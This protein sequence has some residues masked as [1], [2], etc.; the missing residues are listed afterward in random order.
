MEFLRREL[1]PG[2]G[3]A[4]TARLAR[5]AEFLAGDFR[6]DGECKRV[7]ALAGR[8][9]RCP[10][11]NNSPLPTKPSPVPDKHPTPVAVPVSEVTLNRHFVESLGIVIVRNYGPCV[12]YLRLQERTRRGLCQRL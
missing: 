8:T 2:S 5:S 9:Q 3:D 7:E 12:A 11:A 4:A 6:R 10:R 1:I